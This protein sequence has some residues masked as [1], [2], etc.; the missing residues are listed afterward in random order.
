M[1]TKE[2]GMAGEKAAR[3]YLLDM[4]YEIVKSNYK[5]KMGE[6]DIIA[7]SPEEVC[8]FVEV[9]TRKNAD[10]GLACEAVDIRKQKRIIKTAMTYE[11]KYDKRFD[12]IEVYYSMDNEFKTE[13]INHIINAFD[14]SY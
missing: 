14:A 5:T 10:F 12:V 3:E 13:K 1:T 2:I 9:K 6:I 7:I 11:Y 8:A 4:G